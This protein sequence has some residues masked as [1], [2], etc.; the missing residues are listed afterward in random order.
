MASSGGKGRVAFGFWGFHHGKGASGFW[1]PPLPPPPPPLPLPL[2]PPPPPPPPPPLPLRPLG[3]IQV[4][5]V[6]QSCLHGL[7]AGDARGV[8]PKTVCGCLA[9]CI[10]VRASMA[11]RANMGVLSMESLKA[12]LSL[13]SVPRILTR[14]RA[15]SC[16]LA[17]W[18][19]WA[20]WCKETGG[21]DLIQRLGLKV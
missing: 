19:L 13:C 8:G 6:A 20:P 16:V 5:A 18:L 7:P 1:L 10:L 17:P 4:L 3:M 21:K 9:A 11:C 14:P 15:T 2:P 12:C